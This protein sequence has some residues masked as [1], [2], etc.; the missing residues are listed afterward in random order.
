MKIRRNARSSAIE[1]KWRGRT[2]GSEIMLA[3]LVAA[4][5]HGLTR[6]P[7]PEGCACEVTL[8]VPVAP[9]QGGRH[10]TTKQEQ[11]RPERLVWHDQQGPSHHRVPRTVR[12]TIAGGELRS[13]DIH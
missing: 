5:A 12:L 10:G 8:S 4:V 9:A 11:H 13:V 7:L 6:L 1:T 2:S 3:D